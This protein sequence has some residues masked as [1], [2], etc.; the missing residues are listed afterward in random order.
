MAPEENEDKQAEP[1][2]PQ[3]IID[4]NGRLFLTLQVVELE[5]MDEAMRNVTGE[6]HELAVA[7]GQAL[8]ASK[9]DTGGSGPVQVK[10]NPPNS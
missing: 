1:R 7:S 8:W 10:G 6:Q 4:D 2:E 3:F 9:V 5:Q